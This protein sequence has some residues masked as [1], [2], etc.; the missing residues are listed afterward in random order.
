MAVCCLIDLSKVIYGVEDT[1]GE[2]MLMVLN[3]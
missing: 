3:E 1:V 2:Y